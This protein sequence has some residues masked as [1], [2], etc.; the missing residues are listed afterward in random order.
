MA[1]KVADAVPKAEVPQ[2]IFSLG[3]PFKA[4]FFCLQSNGFSFGVF[5]FVPVFSLP[6]VAKQSI[7]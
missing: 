4:F 3:Q 6:S 2:I 5:G 1:V 7:C